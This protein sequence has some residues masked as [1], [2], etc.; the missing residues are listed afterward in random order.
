MQQC[1]NCGGKDLIDEHEV[2]GECAAN[3][4][5]TEKYRKYLAENKK[6]KLFLDTFSHTRFRNFENVNSA[7]SWDFL[8]KYHRYYEDSNT[9]TQLRIKK[10]MEWIPKERSTRVFELGFGYGHVLLELA[11]RGYTNLGGVDISKEAVNYIGGRITKGVFF[12]GDVTDIGLQSESADLVLANE[13]MEHVPPKHTFKVYNEIKRITKREGFVLFS[14]PLGD[15]L[16][17]TTFMCP[18]GQLVNS[19]GHVREYTQEVL[20]LELDT[21]NLAVSRKFLLFPPS[22]GKLRLAKPILK[23]SGYIKPSILFVAAKRRD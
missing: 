6:G 5:I 12:V 1:F 2:C 19:N 11:K 9:V 17:T 21:A 14:V 10:V 20:Q 15:N 18:H 3:P 4:F 8:M 13:V 22:T 23:M 7:K 16:E